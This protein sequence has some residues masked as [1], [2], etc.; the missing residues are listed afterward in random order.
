MMYRPTVVYGFTL[1]LAFCSLIY[2]LVFAQILSVCLGGTRLQYFATIGVFTTFLGLG[3]LAFGHISPKISPRLL[4]L[5]VEISLTAL[6]ALGPFFLTWFL[7]PERAP[8]LLQIGGAFLLIAIVGFLS[9]LE[10]PC[11]LS[12]VP[13]SHGRVLAFD[14]L[15]MLFATVAFPYFLLPEWG[16]GPCAILVA[17]ANATSIGWLWTEKPRR[18]TIV[19][20][21]FLAAAAWWGLFQFRAPLNQVL[22]ALYLGGA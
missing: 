7:F 22:S 19:L 16:I 18:L 9:G 8:M 13:E 15:G 1:I 20:S 3:S 5:R 10:I 14:Y 17:F 11:L 4:L 2:E 6:G 21:F 12:F